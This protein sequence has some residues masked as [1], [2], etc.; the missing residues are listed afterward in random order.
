MVFQFTVAIAK[1]DLPKTNPFQQYAI[2]ES[3]LC[4]ACGCSASGGSMGFASMLNTN[5]IGIRYFNQELFW[6]PFSREVELPEEIDIDKVEAVEDHGLLTI[7]MP[8][9]DKERTN[10]VKIK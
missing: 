3:V 6:G 7:K 9:S 1:N 2:P 10:K 8:K 5:F 4:D